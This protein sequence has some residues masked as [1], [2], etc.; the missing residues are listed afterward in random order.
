MSTRV[1]LGRARNLVLP[2]LAIAAMTAAFAADPP[3]AAQQ[4]AP[5]KEMREK[6]ATLHE[7]MAACLRSD[8]PFA[9]CRA[10]MMKNCQST[11]GAKGCPM[12]DMMGMGKGGMGMHGG[13]MQ[14]PSTSSSPKP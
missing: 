10:E 4:P 8:K 14:D 2:L 12:M 11:M 3:A 9:E 5:S 7:Q 6:M 1:S 13:M